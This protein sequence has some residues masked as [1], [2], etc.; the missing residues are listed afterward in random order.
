MH[1]KPQLMLKALKQLGR[2]ETIHGFRA[3]FATW[4][5]ECTKY[6][7]I[8]AELCLAHMVGNA[9]ERAYRRGELLAMRRQLL[10]DWAR[11]CAS[12]APA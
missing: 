3:A 10:E 8:V 5:S 6:P 4:A 12:Q 1:I 2:T 7:D 9:T 11:Y